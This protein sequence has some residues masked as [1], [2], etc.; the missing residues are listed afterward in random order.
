M[1]TRDPPSQ[2]PSG[3]AVRD[4]IEDPAL[5]LKIRLVAGA[6]GLGREIRHARIQK[7]GLALVGHLHGLVATRVQIL[8]GTELGYVE[9]LGAA[10]QAKS[11][12]ELCSVGPSLILVGRATGS[13]RCRG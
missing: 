13:L 5:G 1:A 12:Q 8:G 3:L 6:A 4:L 10:E 11:A 7:S 9:R 2:V